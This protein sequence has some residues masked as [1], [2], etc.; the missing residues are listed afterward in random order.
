MNDVEYVSGDND[1]TTLFIDTLQWF[2]TPGWTLERQA[3]QVWGN[4]RRISLPNMKLAL[5]T[6]HLCSSLIM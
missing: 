6:A 2:W 5:I 3:L 1:A 4:G